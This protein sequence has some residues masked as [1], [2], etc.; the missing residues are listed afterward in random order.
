MPEN[1]TIFAPVEAPF[2]SYLKDRDE[3]PQPVQDV[4]LWS[5][6]Y[7][8]QAYDPTSGVGFF[9]HVSRMPFNYNIWEGVF[10]CFLPGDRFLVARDFS[11]DTNDKGP[12]SNALRFEVVEPWK[13]WSKTFKGAAQLV[14][15][16]ELRAGAVQDDSH[17]YVEMELT[18]DAMAPVFD[19]GDMGTQFWAHA[20]YEQHGK[21]TGKVAF[22]GTHLGVGAESYEFNGVGMRDHSVGARNVSKLKNHAWLTGEFPS[23]RVFMLMDL[24]LKEGPGFTYIVI[25][26]GTTFTRVQLTNPSPIINDAAD[27]FQS[28]ALEFEGPEGPSVIKAEILQAMPY[29][30][31]GPNE[32]CLGTS[33]KVRNLIVEAQTRFE[34][35]GEVGYGLTE[36]S[37][38]YGH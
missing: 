20:H 29:S 23:G 26:D 25:S 14:T 6:N 22:E 35:D 15:G 38:P 34:W 37:V 24:V 31:T 5:E 18:F 16:D 7:L 3:L 2:P 9:F 13:T 36:R 8:S 17:V 21:Y 11:W 32:W 19:I 12:G 28:Y 33:P 30:F 27:V 4:P 1:A 10:T